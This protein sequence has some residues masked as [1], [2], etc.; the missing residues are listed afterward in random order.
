MKAP[1]KQIKYKGGYKLEHRAIMEEHLGRKL[2]RNEYVH[3]INGNKKDNRLEN[4]MVMTPQAHNDLHKTKLS[5]IKVCKVCGKEFEPPI[6]HRG[7]N[8]ICSHECWLKHQKELSIQH[9]KKI[10]QYTKDNVFVKE[11]GSFHDI[12]RELGIP[13]TNICKVCKGK[14]KSAS[15][16]LWKYKD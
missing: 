6:K 2:E 10:C 15:G 12:E 14:L 11:W 1:Y 13:A 5:R 16:Y 4:L 3:H 7:R 8:T 9:S